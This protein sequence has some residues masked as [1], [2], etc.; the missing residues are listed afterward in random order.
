[1]GNLILVT[2][3]SRSGKS[4]FAQETAEAFLPPRLFM[5]TCRVCDKEMEARVQR[6]RE[7]RNPA[8]WRTVEEP[9]DLAGALSRAGDSTVVLVDCLTL[10]I[11]NL[12]YDAECRGECATDGEIAEQCRH[13]IAAGRAAKGTVIFVSGE[14]GMGIV[15]DNPLARLYR[16]CVGTCNQMAAAAADAVALVASGIPLMLKGA[17]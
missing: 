3:G 10:W 15:P 17:L 9:L 12:L 4:D 11:N 5:A 16:D 7:R 14:V 8:D 6:H 1:M 13:V 2:G